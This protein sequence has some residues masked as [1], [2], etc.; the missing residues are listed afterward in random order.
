VPDQVHTIILDFDGVVVESN[1][2]KTAAFE[3]IFGQFPEH[4]AAMMD[5]HR[6]NV[7]ASRATKFRYFATEL[8]GLPATDPIVEE[9]SGEFSSR[10]AQAIARCP[11]VPGAEEFLLEFAGRIP[12]YLASVTPEPELR[13]ILRA[14]Q[15][16]EYFI[17]I[18]GE[19]PVPKADAVRAVLAR[20]HVSAS[21]ALLV[22]DSP[23]DLQVARSTGVQFIA[24]DSGLPFEPPAPPLLP[25]M[26][27]VAAAVRERVAHRPSAHDMNVR[28]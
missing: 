16:E 6:D 17:D 15:L 4:H 3:A 19:P 2:I 24:R 9:L 18:F 14:R 12:L 7:A 28:R 10:V 8:L 11:L 20:E 13:E 23:G 27:A 25:D 1:E 5:F 22:G 21:N 26:H